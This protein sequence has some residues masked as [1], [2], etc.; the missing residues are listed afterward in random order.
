MG[1]PRI[2]IV[3]DEQHLLTL[4]SEALEGAGFR[5]RGARTGR[6]AL[7]VF[8][9]FQPELVMLDI[10]LLGEMDGFDVLAYLRQRSAVRVMML[11]GQAGDTKLVRGL[12]LG[13]DNYVLKPVSPAGLV[14]RA[15]ALLRRGLDGALAQ[16]AGVFRYPGLE[17][18]LERNRILH[19]DGRR[20]SLH[21]LERRLIARLLQT[22]GQLVSQQELWE[23]A[24][25]ATETLTRW[26]DAK[27]LLSC[28]YRLRSKLDRGLGRPGLIEN[29]R[30]QGF[31]IA[32]PEEPA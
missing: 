32:P 26:D 19:A 30:G 18:D 27:A 8:Q 12:N 9:A 20:Y 29:V 14:A 24:W 6:A 4:Y 31:L 15:R 23:G 13:A 10:T 22:P 2:L 25:H 11:T 28:V 1:A 3:E 17:I 5:T 16:A 21:G 7:E